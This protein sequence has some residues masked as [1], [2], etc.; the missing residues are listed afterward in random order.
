MTIA[1]AVA[2][3]ALRLAAGRRRWD[4]GVRSALG[5][6]ALA[7]WGAAVMWGVDCAA[8]AIEGKPPL[9]LSGEDAVL[10]CVVLCAGLAMFA[11]LAL[12][13]RIR[14]RASAS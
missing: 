10:G 9:D 11:A 7:L 13:G 12:A 4:A 8:D 2:F 1:A 5:T 3:T 6:T 14:S